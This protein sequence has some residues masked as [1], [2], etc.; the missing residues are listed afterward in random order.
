MVVLILAGDK[1]YFED[2]GHRELI[3]NGF[4]GYLFEQNNTM[5]FVEYLKDIYLKKDKRLEMGR[6][7][8]EKAKDFEISKSLEKMSKIYYFYLSR[9]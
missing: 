3:K 1:K 9:K 4:N 2:R 5:Q 8:Y 7:A 6:N